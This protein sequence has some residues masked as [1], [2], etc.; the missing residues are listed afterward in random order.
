MDSTNKVRITALLGSGSTLQVGGPTTTALSEAVRKK[1]QFIDEIGKR[2]DALLLPTQCNFEDIFDVLETLQ[3]WGTGSAPGT[4]PRYKP[5]E[6]P[7]LDHLDPRWLDPVKIL[8]A[9]RDLIETVAEEVEQSEKLF[10]PDKLHRWFRN[11]WALPKGD[12][13]WDI[14]TLNYDDILELALGDNNCEDGYVDTGHGYCR[15]DPRRIAETQKT[16]LMH[17]HGSIRYGYPRAVVN[18]YLFED[19]HE[20]LYKLPTPQEARL[21]WFGRS[22]HTS[23][24]HRTNIIGP[25]ITGLQKPDKLTLYPY[26]QYQAVLRRCVQDSPRLLVVGY[27]FGDLY[28]NGILQRISRLHG[29]SR[30]VVVVTYFPHKEELWHP[31]PA[32]SE[33]LS[34]EMLGFLGRA[35]RQSEP[36]GNSHVFQNPIASKDGHCR[37]YLRGTEDAFSKNPQDLIGFL[38]S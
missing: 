18:Q 37:I 25:L 35:A 19:T 10:S 13:A 23:Q 31:D 3:S 26:D 17:L 28:L 29:D 6:I 34:E 22:T 32:V 38:L 27:S 4:A 30:R 16:R 12:Y 20:D 14:G 11:F 9:V 15:F 1:N 7:F 5:R 36:L 24:S 21:T 8:D 2:L 33:W